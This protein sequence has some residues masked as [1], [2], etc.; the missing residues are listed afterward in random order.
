MYQLEQ[1]F[2]LFALWFRDVDIMREDPPYDGYYYHKAKKTLLE[3][4]LA[5][6]E[7]PHLEEVL[8]SVRKVREGLSRSIK[9][10]VCFEALCLDC[11]L[12]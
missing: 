9:P 6:P 2:R 10:E 4:A 5:S 3:K 12:V 7:T 8:E 11:K 1:Y